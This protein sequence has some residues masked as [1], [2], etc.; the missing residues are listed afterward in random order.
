MDSEFL[1]M[2]I[3]IVIFLPFVLFLIYLSLKLSGGKFQSFQKG[4]YIKVLERVNVSKDSSIMLIKIGEEYH[5]MSSTNNGINEIRALTK[6]EALKY[7]VDKEASKQ[8]FKDYK[9]DLKRLI[10]KGRFKDE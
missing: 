7:E 1:K 3:Q 9:E 5:I 10:K 2:I 6:E 4:K 8:G